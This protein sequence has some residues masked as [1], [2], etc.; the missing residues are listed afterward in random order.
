MQTCVVGRGR[1]T[2]YFNPELVPSLS[3][4]PGGLTFISW[5]VLK[6]SSSIH[7]KFKHLGEVARNELVMNSHR[8]KFCLYLMCNCQVKWFNSVL[9]TEI[10]LQE[11]AFLTWAWHSAD[12]RGEV[13]YYPSN[14]E[15]WFGNT[16]GWSV[17][18]GKG[19]EIDFFGLAA[20]AWSLT[21]QRRLKS[22]WGSVKWNV[23]ID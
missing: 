11:V 16:V 13:L 20:D 1:L 18:T 23:R 10:L 19:W 21:K 3:E 14:A 15:G 12:L 22:R 9:H 6:L 5:D 7:W 2:L 8:D 4:C 17:A